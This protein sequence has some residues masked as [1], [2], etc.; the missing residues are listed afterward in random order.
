MDEKLAEKVAKKVINENKKIDAK[1]ALFLSMKE[2]DT[3]KE[4]KNKEKVKQQKDKVNNKLLFIV[5]K[6][7]VKNISAWEALFD[8]G[9]IRSVMEDLDIK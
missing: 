1:E 6:G 5:E 3:Y 2:I 4:D 9:M 8:A 7:K